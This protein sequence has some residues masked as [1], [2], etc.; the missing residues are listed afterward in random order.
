M[1][2]AAKVWALRSRM[3]QEHSSPFALLRT[4]GRVRIEIPQ[5]PFV[6]NVEV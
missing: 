6:S 4:G 2:A 3:R 1:T 5:F